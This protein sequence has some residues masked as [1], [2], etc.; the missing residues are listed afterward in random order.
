MVITALRL[1]QHEFG[2]PDRMFHV[3]QGRVKEL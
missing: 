3:E 1:D 2:S